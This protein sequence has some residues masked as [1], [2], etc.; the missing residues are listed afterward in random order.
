M[1]I[2]DKAKIINGLC[3]FFMLKK[4]F[5]KKIEEFLSKKIKQKKQKLYI[6]ILIRPNYYTFFIVIV[7]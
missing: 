4:I 2:F 1:C 5:Q 7:I 6:G 3:L